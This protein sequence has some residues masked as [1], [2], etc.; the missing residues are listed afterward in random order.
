MPDAYA[1]AVVVGVIAA[2]G[3]RGEE[4]AAVSQAGRIRETQAHSVDL[5]E[6]VTSHSRSRHRLRCGRRRAN[7]ATRVRSSATTA[8][9]APRPLPRWN[10][11]RCS[12]DT[13]APSMLRSGMS[14]S[15]TSY[16]GRRSSRR[17]SPVSA[18]RGSRS[19]NTPPRRCGF[20]PDSSASSAPGSSASASRSGFLR[21]R[22]LRVRG[23]LAR[24]EPLEAPRRVPLRGEHSQPAVVVG[25]HVDVVA[26]TNEAAPRGR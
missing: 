25:D 9:T 24:E 12:P 23:Q 7:R 26:G 3:H 10:S 19:H 21:L 2:L 8:F 20:D 15:S 5:A 16:S 18:P 22:S 14:R 11:S 6:V 17:G 1:L 4:N 13:V